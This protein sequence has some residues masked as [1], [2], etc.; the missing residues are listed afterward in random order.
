MHRF[1]VGILVAC[2]GLCS[3]G[4]AEWDW[5]LRFTDGTD[6]SLKEVNAELMSRRL[7]AVQ[8]YAVENKSLDLDGFTIS[9]AQGTLFVEEPVAGHPAGAFFEGSAQVSLETDSASMGRRLSKLFG[10]KGLSSEPVDAFYI[11]HAGGSG[12]L[13]TLGVE[14][15]PSVPPTSNPA[16]EKC[17]KVLR[18]TGMDM[19]HAHHYG[20]EG[21]DVTHVLF[22]PASIR[23]PGS[24][25]A[26]LLFSRDSSSRTDMSLAVFGHKDVF[27]DVRMRNRLG[28]FQYRFWPIASVLGG[29]DAVQADVSKY[30]IDIKVSRGKEVK[31]KTT[32]AFTPARDLKTIRLKLSKYLYVTNVA[33]ASGNSLKFA[34]WKRIETDDQSDDSVMVIADPPL[35]AGE[36]TELVVTSNGPLVSQF[37]GSYHMLDEDTWYPQFEETGVSHFEI[38]C[39][40]PKNLKAVAA[41]EKVSE[42]KVDGGKRLVFK[43]KEPSQWATFYFGTYKVF[44]DKAD[45]TNIELYQDPMAEFSTGLDDPRY[46]VAEIA[47]AVRIY[48][49]ILDHFLDIDTLRVASTPTFHGRGFEGL[50]LLSQYAGSRTDSSA[51]DLFR[52][53]EVAHQWWGHVVKPSNWSEDRWLGEAFAEYVA[54]EYF[55]L[56][57]NEKVA[58]TREQMREQ[59][60]RPV[61]FSSEEKTRT[62]T[63]EDSRESTAEMSALTDGGQN[64]YTKGPLVIHH[65]RF[66]FH[67]Q[68]KG[69]QGFWTFI[70]DFIDNHENQFVTT[71]DF[72]ASAEKALGGKLDWFWDQWLYG[73]RIPEVE[74]SHTVRQSEDGKWLLEIE[75]E[76]KDTEYIFPLAVYLHFKGGKTGTVPLPV[77]G[78]TGSL[79][80]PLADKPTKVTI[81]DNFE[82]PVRISRR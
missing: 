23:T 42:K 17:K 19:L 77:N 3:V 27:T 48:N 37:G 8:G 21:G 80:V 82:T 52:A 30:T 26:H 29:D 62:L 35:K 64:V 34:Q 59:W 79:K 12:L 9:I 51:S 43:T 22:S 20:A 81:N 78:K 44:K 16:Y 24:E 1:L 74:W 71:D 38:I 68:R 5:K 76:Q 60:W 65:L 55:H 15:E 7:S 39:T 6:A 75:A 53:H 49:R 46:A 36:A 47:N 40:L 10:S 28:D 50:I 58:K 11:F 33:D 54:M 70:Q 32:I 45:E 25:D 67:A 2:F 41:G 57:N 31:S 56:R 73:A 63:G 13:E 61:F 14:G 72:I 18:H 66:L 4:A 69:D